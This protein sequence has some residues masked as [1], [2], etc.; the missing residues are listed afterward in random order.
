MFVTDFYKLY[1]LYGVCFMDFVIFDSSS[2]SLFAKFVK[3]IRELDLF[4]HHLVSYQV[5]HL[6]F[7]LILISELNLYDVSI[8][9]LIS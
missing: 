4:L 9:F 2:V 1:Y 7:E 5:F 8:S 6:M 3:L